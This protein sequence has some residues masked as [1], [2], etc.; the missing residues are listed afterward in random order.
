MQNDKS[1]RYYYILQPANQ[2]LQPKRYRRDLLKRA[3]AITNDGSRLTQSLFTYPATT[4]A[5]GHHLC[6]V[7]FDFACNDI[8]A[9]A[10]QYNFVNNKLS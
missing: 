5:H 7:I 10:V 6:V 9:C 4:Y 3:I 2:G 1:V 8:Y